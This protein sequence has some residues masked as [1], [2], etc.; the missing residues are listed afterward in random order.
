MSQEEF[1]RELVELK[2]ILCI[3]MELL[4]HSSTMLMDYEEE[5]RLLEEWL[6]NPKGERDCLI[7]ADIEYPRMLS[8]INVCEGDE[9]Q[10]IELS[11]EDRMLLHTQQKYVDQNIIL[12]GNKEDEGN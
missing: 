5:L 6:D 7:V 1:D 2:E 8:C 12:R 4:Q 3:I 11:F 10:D 9:G